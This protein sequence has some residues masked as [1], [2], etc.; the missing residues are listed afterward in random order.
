MQIINRIISLLV[1]AVFIFSGFVKLV[2]PMGLAIKLEE[3]FQVFQEDFSSLNVLWE[4]LLPYTLS[5]GILLSMAEVVLGF[6]LVLAYKVRNTLWLL[7]LLVIFFGFLTFYSAY[8]NKVTDCGCF[9]D[10]IPLEPWES[11]YKDMVLLVLIAVLFF[12]KK[13][14]GEGSKFVRLTGLAVFLS[15]VASIALAVYAYRHLPPIDFRAY[16]VGANIP[17]LMQASEELKYEYILEKDGKTETFTEYPSDTTYKF[18]EMK[19]L[20]PEAQA[21]ITDY[22]VWNDEGDFTKKTFEGE[23]LLIIVPD[24]KHSDPESVVTADRLV[25]ALKGKTKIEGMILTAAGSE[26][27][28]NFV[29]AKNIQ[30]A[31]YFADKKV[32]KTM[33]RANPGLIRLRE[34]IVLEKWHYHDFPAPEYF[35]D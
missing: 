5:L 4:F 32:L 18:K 35:Q 6:S 17:A 9:G 14:L 33:V 28:A 29:K 30:T 21:K 22:N 25:R 7:L 23:K 11:F 8:F 16:K 34:G 31:Y 12:Q 10:A 19:L 20:N 15:G 24:L 26:D 2:D 1:G 13:P 27:F 3:Y